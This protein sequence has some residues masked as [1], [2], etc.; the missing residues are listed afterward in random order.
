[1][2]H[3]LRHAAITNLLD[4]GASLAE[5]QDF[6]GHASPVTTRRY[7]RHRRADTAAVKLAQYL[8]S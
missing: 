7:D 1:V 6:A 2:P 5:A 8:A 3:D 4:A